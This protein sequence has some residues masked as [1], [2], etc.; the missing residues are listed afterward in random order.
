MSEEID[1]KPTQFYKPNFELDKF[2]KIAFNATEAGHNV[3]VCAHTS[4]GKT[5]VAKNA[6]RMHLKNNNGKQIIYTTPIKVLS[7][8]INNQLSIELKGIAEV[9]IITGNTTK[10][11]NAEVIIMTT[12]VL[13]NG[14]FRENN[15][16]IYD[17]NFNPEK[18]SCVIFDEVHFINDRDRGHVWEQTISKLNKNI[19]LIML[20]A[21]LSGAEKL[22][23]WISEIKNKYCHLIITDKRPIKLEHSL[24]LEYE[25]KFKIVLDDEK[26][27]YGTW[28]KVLDDFKKNEK[29]EKLKSK[30]K[31]SRHQKKINR[32][33]LC[34]KKL[35]EDNLFPATFFI[36]NRDFVESIGKDFMSKNYNFISNDE[37]KE[38]ENIWNK[39]LHTF[40]DDLIQTEQYKFIKSLTQ[41]GLGIHHSGLIPLL[42]EV[43]EILYKSKLLK[44]LIATE[45]FAMGVNMPTRTVVHTQLTKWD[46]V[47][48][49][50]FKPSEYTQMS[51]RA[52]RRG[53]DKKGNVILLIDENTPDETTAK[54]ILIAKPQKV[55]SQ[56]KL[57]YNYILKR[58]NLMISENKNN[59]PYDYLIKSINNSYKNNETKEII[60]YYEN[61]IKKLNNN[62]FIDIDNETKKMYKSYKELNQ[63][64]KD[65]ESETIKMAPNTKKKIIKNINK[66]KNKFPKD[67]INILEEYYDNF[68]N[69]KRFEKYIF[70]HQN[71]FKSQI[72]KIMK[73]LKDYKLI[74][75]DYNLTPLGRIVSEVNECN[76]LI[77]GEIISKGYLNKL[78]FS[79]IV[80]FLSIFINDHV[81]DE[82]MLSDIE[83]SDD[84]KDMLIKIST[85]IDNLAYN[86]SKLNNFISI[87]INSNWNI[88]LSL[89]VPIKLWAEGKEWLEV[90]KHYKSFE[91]NFIKNVIRI[92]NLLR[93]VEIIAKITN[94]FNLLNKID[95]YLEKLIRGFVSTDS[96]YLI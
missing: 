69:I 22:A 80:A 5:V 50:N 86:E 41:K 93:N 2:Q 75:K 3:M 78:N 95:G 20:S 12:E 70:N 72:S 9:G 38:I 54:R 81:I 55:E 94:D 23:K 90:K 61:E 45:T 71:Q 27:S 28:N 26:W 76:P 35:K 60:N 42:G 48:T 79:E 15:D 68:I 58:L 84:F 34:L 59:D 51:G 7:N 11:P 14:L 66:L 63:K 1:K 6:I 77:M 16:K 85:F 17:W 33:N 56:F 64:L 83:I 91:G 25:N 13:Y 92:S 73:Y 53:M 30:K 49:R 52:G 57:D 37:Q 47:G 24:Y 21:T 82:P 65:N 67:K 96:L 19:Q 31:I 88:Y 89:F 32:I 87:K 40:K 36:L 74:E 44:V 8:Q 10:N 4:S 18:V 29:K 39:Y 62:K 43:I 46:G